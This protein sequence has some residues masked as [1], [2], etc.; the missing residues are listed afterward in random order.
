MGVREKKRYLLIEMTS[1]AKLD[2]KTA[3]RLLNSALS[4]VYGESGL[5]KTSLKLIEFDETSQK[6]IA[7]VN[8]GFY[9]QSTAA[10]SLKRFFENKSVLLRVKKASGSVVKL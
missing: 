5:A 6:A 8:L 10:F 1:E 3:A 7:K 2:S 9:R 4:E